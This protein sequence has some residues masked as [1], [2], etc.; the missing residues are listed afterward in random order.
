MQSEHRSRPSVEG[1]A[2]AACWAGSVAGDDTVLGIPSSIRNL[3]ALQELPKEKLRR[4][5]MPG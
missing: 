3:A 4:L 1:G 2:I 5:I